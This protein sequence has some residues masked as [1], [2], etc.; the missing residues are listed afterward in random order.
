[1]FIMKEIFEGEIFEECPESWEQRIEKHSWLRENVLRASKHRDIPFRFVV[2]KKYVCCEYTKSINLFT[3][4]KL[5]F[6]IP[7]TFIAMPF[8]I[9]EPGFSGDLNALID[10]YRKRKGFFILL[11]LKS[12]D[13]IDKRHPKGNTLCTCVFENRFKNFEDYILRLRSNYRR[14]ISIAQKKGKSLIIKRINS[15]DFNDELH[16][17]Y[18]NVLGNS[19]Y[20]LETLEKGFFQTID[21]DIHVFYKDEKPV[22]F[23]STKRV[24]NTLHFLLGGMD[25]TVLKELDLYYNMLLHIV[26]LGIEQKCNKINFGQTGEI[27]KLR[28]G[29]TFEKR[30]MAAIISNSFVNSIIKLLRPFIEYRFPEQN[31][32]VFK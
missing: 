25:Y 11:N 6:N 30:Y 8:S 28:I 4:G 31:N 14:R 15:I 26:R 22:A 10:D 21:S 20:P 5:N 19:K 29:C 9:D 7:V 1:M 3:F 32:R 24:E 27:S 23:I 16:R 18:L 12:I 13:S 2:H 17:L